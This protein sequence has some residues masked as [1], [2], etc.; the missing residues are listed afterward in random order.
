MLTQAPRLR[1]SGHG[2]GLRVRSIGRRRHDPL[3]DVRECCR[4]SMAVD[5]ALGESVREAI[6]TGS[7]WRD[8]GRAL[9]VS[10]DADTRAKVID[11]L[12][13]SKRAVW[14]RFWQ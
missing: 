12:A 14:N 2:A 1:L 8:V 9:G 11:A 10:E 7:S 6:A 3:E 13:E 5:K 4:A